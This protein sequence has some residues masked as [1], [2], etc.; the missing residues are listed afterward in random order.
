MQLV[1]GRGISTFL[2]DKQFSHRSGLMAD[3]AKLS[4]NI[5]GV[6]THEV[7]NVMNDVADSSSATISGRF[8]S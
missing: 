4:T 5:P 7:S 8:S 1:F 6:D 3:T 2:A